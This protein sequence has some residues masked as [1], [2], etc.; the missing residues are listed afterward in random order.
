MHVE[1]LVSD[2]SVNNVSMVT[3]GKAAYRH[4][5][6]NMINVL[7]KIFYS[8]MQALKITIYGKK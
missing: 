7:L 1:E 6:N 3:R 2:K 4:F 5:C 8:Q